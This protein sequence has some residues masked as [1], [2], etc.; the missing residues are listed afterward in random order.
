MNNT[1]PTGFDK[2]L[3]LKLANDSML[4]YVQMNDPVNFIMP[5][6]YTLVAAFT[7]DVLGHTELMGY[8]MKSAT[9]AVLAFRGTDDF[10]D[11]MA[12][13]RYTQAAFPFV[14]TAGLTHAGFTAVYQSARPA[15]QA[16]VKSLPAGITLYITGH[17]LGGAVATLAALDIAA[18]TAFKS[19]IVYTIASPRV[20]TAEL[21][22][23]IRQRHRHQPDAK[24]AR[25]E[26]ARPGAALAAQRYLRSA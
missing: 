1:I 10:P 14:A 26:H 16:A 24:L 9:D 8:L 5:P 15:V 4:A 19:P 7:G 6:G 21:R 25:G 3:A 12:D 23:P 17:S 20:G 22:K 18:N 13:M 2:T 11:A